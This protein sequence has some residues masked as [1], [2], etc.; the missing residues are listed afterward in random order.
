MD[1]LLARKYERLKRIIGSYGSLLVAYSGGVD[2]TLLLRAASDALGDNVLAVKASSAV[3][4]R[5][6]LSFAKK[7]ARRLGVRLLVVESDE[8]A[9]RT[10]IRNLPDRCYCCKLRL[11]KKLRALA[12]REKM[13]RVAVASH[14]DDLKDYR[15]GEKAVREMGVVSPLR[16]AG[17]TKKDVR[18]LSRRLGLPGWDREAMACLAS[19]IP[20]GEPI[21]GKKLERVARAEEFLR[22]RGFK[23]VRVRCPGGNARIEVEETQIGGFRDVRLRN[24]VVGKLKSLGFQVVSLDLEG[25]RMGSLNR[26]LVK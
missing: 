19:R 26:R 9:D 13:A 23:N 2:S 16:L 14:L 21:D 3:H 18:R 6:E 25:Y 4:P 15:P 8:L 10:F 12:R 22:R 5:S 7:T 17:F 20:Y 1:R 11:L 24:A